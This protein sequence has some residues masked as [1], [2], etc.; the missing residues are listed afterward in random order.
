MHLNTYKQYIEPINKFNGL[1]FYVLKQNKYY[2]RKEEEY[3]VVKKKR[4]YILGR[5]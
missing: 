2:H 5:T 3:D 4:K 1:Y